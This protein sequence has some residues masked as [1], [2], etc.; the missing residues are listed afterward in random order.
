MKKVI[1]I[2]L[3]IILGLFISGYW[4]LISTKPVYDGEIELSGIQDQ[5]TVKFDQYGIPHIYA[6]N[7]KDAYFALG[8]LQ[9][10]ERLFQMEMI[11]RVASGTLSEILGPDFIETDKLFRTL[12]FERKSKEF[13]KKF[14]QENNEYKAAVTSYFKGINAFVKNGPTPLEFSVIGIPK[15][16]FSVIDAYN[17]VGYMSFGFADGFKVDPITSKMAVTLDNRYLEDIGLHSHY[18]STF[19]KSYIKPESLELTRLAQVIDKIPIPLID[20]SNSWIVS[21][22]KSGSGNAIFENDAHIGYSQPSVWFEAHLEYPGFSLYG[23]YLAGFPFA[24]LGHNRYAAWGLTMFENDD[25]DLYQE[26]SNPDNQDQIWRIDK[27]I[28]LETRKETIEVKDSEQVD[29]TI[30]VS[31]HGPVVNDLFFKDSII[32]EPVSVWWEYLNTDKDLFKPIY[33]MGQCSSIEE[34]R[35]AA[36]LIQA[37][38]L[39]L[40]YADTD[41][42]I[43]WWATA[44]IPIRPEHVNS[45]ILLDG[46]SGKDD[47]LGYYDFKN[48]PQ[49]ENPP[50]N[51][52]YTANNQPDTVNGVLY[53]GYYR[54]IDRASSIENRLL[55]KDDWTAEDFMSMTATA[56]SPIA[57][58]VARELAKIIDQSTDNN[59]DQLAKFLNNW[60]G[61]HQKNMIE[62]TI[63]YNVLSWTLY[64]AMGDELG[65]ED[66]HT[67]VNSEVMKR[68]YLSFIRNENSIWWDNTNTEEVE[69]RLTIVADGFKAALNTLYR[70]FNSENPEDWKW[71]QVHTL[72]HNHPLGQVDLLKRYFN[73]GPFTSASGNEVI[74]NMLFKLDTTGYFP[75][76][77]GPSQ[78]T[79]IDMGDI[80]GAMSSNPTGQSG[81]FL[82]KHY[83]DQAQMFIDVG[84]RPQLMNES[85][86]EKNKISVLTLLPQSN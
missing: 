19:L 1:V 37:P 22:E 28:D 35:L 14:N 18:D 41:N 74:N 62:P 40:M 48:N 72:T 42:N 16:E 70:T 50:W 24:V 67:L 55:D 73:V 7:Q 59:Y 66:F 31:D 53:P 44:R 46:S 63:Y 5:V 51:Y 4:Y 76:L 33:L 78:R 6:S 38:G 57:P 34:A 27:W 15:R 60:N 82:S 80:E 25:V 75:I 54:P 21:P 29:F 26:K 36:S 65:Y 23:H 3:I 61:D 11:R 45:K 83:N 17:A 56:K 64:F 8:Y 32:T 85:V 68:S 69:T 49:A 20:G 52:V 43:G 79:V 71:E 86:I 10:Q 39:N 9:A 47:I 84:F 12:G 30:K 81:H 2:I 77:A 13:V 58:L